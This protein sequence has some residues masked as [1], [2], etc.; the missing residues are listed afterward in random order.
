MGVKCLR[1][2]GLRFRAWG[3]GYGNLRILS[4]PPPH[5]PANEYFLERVLVPYWGFIVRRLGA[6]CSWRRFIRCLGL[7]VEGQGYTGLR[8]RLMKNQMDEKF[9]IICRYI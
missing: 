4:G 6:C 7:R 1:V 9:G 5:P 8:E 2:Q 3:L